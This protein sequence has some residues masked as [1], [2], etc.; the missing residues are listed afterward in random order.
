MRDVT[1]TEGNLEASLS[2]RVQ[3]VYVGHFM[4][5]GDEIEMPD[6]IRALR[7]TCY[8][9]H[10][11]PGRKH[12]DTVQQRQNLVIGSIKYTLDSSRGAEHYYE[13]RSETDVVMI[14]V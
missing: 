10:V 9:L 3:T 4:T 11:A 8:G 13:Q 1:I 14:R 2:S 7:T 5:S 12:V 6:T